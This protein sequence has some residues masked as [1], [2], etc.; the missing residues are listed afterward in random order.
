VHFASGATGNRKIL[1]RQ[2]NQPAIH[3]GAAR[4]YS[5]RWQVLACHV[6]ISGTVFGEEADFL[7]ASQVD[8]IF[9]ALASRELTVRMML[10]DS[11]LAAALLDQRSLGAQL[12][13]LCLYRRFLFCRLLREK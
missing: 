11:F 6:E 10:V 4:D 8:E 1:A 7:K 5:I 13:N 12:G 9:H 3:R 2:M